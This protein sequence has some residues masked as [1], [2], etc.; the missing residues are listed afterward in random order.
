MNKPKRECGSCQQWVKWKNDRWGRGL[1]SLLDYATTAQ[2]GKGCSYW[3][4]KKY[5]RLQK[6]EPQI[7]I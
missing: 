4:G 3:S 5:V 7:E 6:S 2:M 1:C